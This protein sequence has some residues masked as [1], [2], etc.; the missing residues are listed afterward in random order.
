MGF[1]LS[2][3]GCSVVTPGKGTR[4]VLYLLLLNPKI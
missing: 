1:S 2:S 4:Y 3:C